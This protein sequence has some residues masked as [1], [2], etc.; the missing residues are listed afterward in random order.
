MARIKTILTERVELHEQSKE[1]LEQ[2]ERG[3]TITSGQLASQLQRGEVDKIIEGK[4]IVRERENHKKRE[5]PLF[6]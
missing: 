4:R 6:R 1:L 2:S 3:E 5:H